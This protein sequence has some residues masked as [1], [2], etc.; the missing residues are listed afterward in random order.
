MSKGELRTSAII[1]EIIS[2]SEPD[3][4]EVGRVDGSDKALFVPYIPHEAHPG[5]DGPS[6]TPAMRMLRMYSKED[7]E[8]C[9]LDKWG[10]VDPGLRRLD[11]EGRP[12]RE[13]CESPER[14][15]IWLTSRP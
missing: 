8:Q 15:G 12:P 2:Q 1:R 11:G 4:G 7:L 9:P 13:D 14:E 5:G 6:E 10:I 3:L